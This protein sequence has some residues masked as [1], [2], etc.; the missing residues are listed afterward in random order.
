MMSASYA[1]RLELS[2]TG[3]VKPVTRLL[4]FTSKNKIRHFTE[5]T[6]LNPPEADQP[7]TITYYY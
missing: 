5:K 2:K 3:S 6:V 7:K 4:S 1:D